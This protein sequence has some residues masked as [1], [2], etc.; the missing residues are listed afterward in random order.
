MWGGKYS[1]WRSDT[2]MHRI[3]HFEK[4]YLLDK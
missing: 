4:F 2:D 3:Y 1:S